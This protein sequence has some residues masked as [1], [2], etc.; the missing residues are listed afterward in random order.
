M[1]TQDKKELNIEEVS[2]VTG[3]NANGPVK[4]TGPSDKID[5]I[6]QHDE[7]TTGIPL[8]PGPANDSFEIKT[9]PLMPG[10]TQKPDLISAQLKK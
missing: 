10:P 3:G 1:T 7:I 8:A 2:S 9:E 4:G 5:Q 6:Y